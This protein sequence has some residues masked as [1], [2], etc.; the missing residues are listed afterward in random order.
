MKSSAYPIAMQPTSRSR[1]SLMGGARMFVPMVIAQ[2]ASL[3][4]V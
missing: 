3:Q 1:E 2:G 4:S